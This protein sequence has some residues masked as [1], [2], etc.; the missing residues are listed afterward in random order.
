VDGAELIVGED[1][2][3][4]DPGRQI[5]GIARHLA[6]LQVDWRPTG[7][8]RLGADLNYRSGVYLRGDEVNVLGRTG[9]F[10]TLNLRGEYRFNDALTAF[11]RI[12][13]VFDTD[14]ETF[15]LLGEPDE[16][17]EDFEDPRFLGAG[18]PRGIWAG[19]R[20]KL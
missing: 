8:M 9:S 20:L 18:A 5:P 12:E 15:G 6:N 13:N 16:V 1:K 14:Y 4:V 19:F 17:F 10:V 2:L 3:R 11:A 7:A